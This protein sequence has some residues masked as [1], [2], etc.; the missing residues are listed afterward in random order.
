MKSILFLTFLFVA[1]FSATSTAQ[2]EFAGGAGLGGTKLT[3]DLG[4]GGSFGFN[5]YLEGKYFVTEHL[6]A[7][8]EY[9]SAAVGYVDENS[10]TGMSY[11][12]N[13]SFFAKGEYFLTTGK[14]RPYVGAAIGLSHLRTPEFIYTSGGKKHVIPSET[15]MNVGISPR[16]GL[17]LGRFGMEFNYTFSGKTPNTTVLNVSSSNK[18]FNFYAITFKYIYSL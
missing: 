3:G 13:K 8:L 14:V 2:N 10:S 6:A 5:Y 17:M 1:A 11:Y 9:N 4:K 7:G 12:G 15:K 16:L 18:A